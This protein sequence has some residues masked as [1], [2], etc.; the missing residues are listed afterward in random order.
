MNITI[1]SPEIMP[2]GLARSQ[3]QSSGGGLGLPL[4]AAYPQKQFSEI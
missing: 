2:R 1:A 4:P 3:P